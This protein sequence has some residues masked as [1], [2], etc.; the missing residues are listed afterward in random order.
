MA[1]GD[2]VPWNWNKKK[3]SVAKSR[4]PFIAMQR[5]MNDL[6]RNFLS[7]SP[8]DVPS[9]FSEDSGEFVPKVNVKEN[10]KEIEVTAELPGLTQDQINLSLSDDALVISGEKQE[11][12]EH[13]DDKAHRYIERC[14]GSFQRVI[15]LGA[16]IDQ[17]AIDAT[18]KSGVLTVKLPKVASSQKAKKVSIRSV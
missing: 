11:E 10:E 4:D 5:Q 15:P 2:L 1:I 12:H 18:F 13:K 8:W 6:F 7:D 14:F 9:V 16:E 3:L 17:D